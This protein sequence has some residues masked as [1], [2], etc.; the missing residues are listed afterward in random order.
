M[1][2]ESTSTRRIEGE[3]TITVDGERGIVELN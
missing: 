3:Q 1:K 2:S